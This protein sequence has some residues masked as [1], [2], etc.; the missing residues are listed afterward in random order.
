M[1]KIV[2]IAT[3]IVAAMT[4]TAQS[5]QLHSCTDQTKV[6]ADYNY[7]SD[8]WQAFF[9]T[10]SDIRTMSYTYT[11]MF[12]ERRIAGGLNAHAEV[13]LFTPNFGNVY[14]GGL[15]Y[16]IGGENWF[17]EAEG[18]Y[19]Y[20]TGHDW[21]FTI[22]GGYENKWLYY[23]GYV[24][25]WGIEIVQW[26][27]ENKFYWKATDHFQLG[28]NILTDYKTIHPMLTIRITK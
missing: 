18:L 22:V 27:S 28:I 17:I 20:D 13:R 4:A 12:V 1:K 16:S 9:Y 24:D 21:Q 2:F 3:M 6:V 5:I 7:M 8:G 11:Q 26:F 15:G 23:E 19:R 14:I 25:F 10:E